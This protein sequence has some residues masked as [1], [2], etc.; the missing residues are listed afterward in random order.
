MVMA[1]DW[2]K[3]RKTLLKD[4]RVRIVSRTCHASTVTV[5]GALVTLWCLA[6]DHADENGELHGYTKDDINTEVGLEGFCE[7][8]PDDW[9][10]INGEWVKLPD[11]QEHN[12]A[13][14]KKRA[15]DQQ[16]Q[17]RHRT[18]TDV[19]RTDRDKN[20]TREEKRR[21]ENN[22]GDKPTI[23]K[24]IPPSLQEVITYCAERGKG[25]DSQNWHDFYTAKDWMIGKNK[26]KDWKAAVRTWE[27]NQSSNND[28]GL[29]SQLKGAL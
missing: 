13:T 5:V 18:V 10:D 14:A 27:K 29:S 9:I 20:A 16:R 17:K 12:G 1:G 21:E 11:Y 2:I 6:D 23:K 3:F 19:S 26:M 8:L 7:S 28:G 25:V 15:Q 24:F 22:R 4:G